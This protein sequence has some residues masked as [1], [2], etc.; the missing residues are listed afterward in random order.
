MDRITGKVLREWVKKGWVSEKKT[1]NVLNIGKSRPLVD[2]YYE[3]EEP[4]LKVV[5]PLIVSKAL[6]EE[7]KPSPYI[8]RGIYLGAGLNQK[9]MTPGYLE[10]EGYYFAEINSKKLKKEIASRLKQQYNLDGFFSLQE[11]KET[12]EADVLKNLEAILEEMR[13]KLYDYEETIETLKE[14]FSTMRIS[15]GIRMELVTGF[16]KKNIG[17]LKALQKTE[18]EIEKFIEYLENLLHNKT[19]YKKGR[20]SS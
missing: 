16:S 6:P 7:N 4:S 11:I 10:M 1:L 17:E 12:L 2:Y 19:P 13:K 5:V 15:Q 14:E 20:R 3:I 18:N 9:P 8:I